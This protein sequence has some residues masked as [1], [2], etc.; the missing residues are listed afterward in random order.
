[1][2]ILKRVQAVTN[3]QH[4]GPD[5]MRPDGMTVLRSTRVLP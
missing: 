2:V 5:R 1:V 3:A 4:A